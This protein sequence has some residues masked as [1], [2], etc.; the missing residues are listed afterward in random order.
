MV[1]ARVLFDKGKIVNSEERAIEELVENLRSRRAWLHTIAVADLFAFFDLAV[2]QWN[3]N[4]SMFSKNLSDYFTSSRL[5]DSLTTALRSELKVLDHYCDIGD[6]QFLVHAQPRGVSVH[7]L[8]G[9]VSILGLFSIFSAL[10]TKNVCLVKA[11]SRGYA[12]LVALLAELSSI[13]NSPVDVV[14]L[15]SCI[16]V[17]LIDRDDREAQEALSMAA[18]VR[19]AWGG[20]EA[21]ATVSALPK[22]FYCEDI[23]FG[24]KYSFA[25]IDSIS[26]QSSY[27]K[28]AQRLAIDIS[29]FDQYACSSPHT[30]FVQESESVSSLQF[31]E[32]LAKQM[33][34]VNRTLL[35]K[36]KTDP[37]KSMEIVGLRSEYAITGKVFHSKGT[38]WTVLYSEEYG[39]FEGCF[40]RVVMVKKITDL[41]EIKQYV[42]RQMQTLGIA[43]ST[44][45]AL[46]VID[47]L[48]LMGIDRCPDLGTMTFFEPI[49]DG[50]FLF[51]RLVRWVTVHKKI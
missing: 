37:G 27:K 47:E 4:K 43:L 39:M 23:I 31:A 9:N 10:I 22:N 34:L 26:L 6:P 32:E 38:E 46:Q 5:K 3:Q 17:V 49:W 8:A 29:V 13:Q 41:L 35:P 28:L 45:N 14:Q 33:D 18:D 36:G 11:S 1:S 7:W 48:T 2:A 44:E 25:L 15:L 16:T 12:E 51:D 40:S 24:P 42:T 21:I 20:Q 30:V 50:M 19:I